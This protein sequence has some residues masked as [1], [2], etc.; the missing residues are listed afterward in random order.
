MKKTN[1]V[2]APQGQSPYYTARPNPHGE[3]PPA[4]VMRRRRSGRAGRFFIRLSA[5]LLGLIVGFGAYTWFLLG[6]PLFTDIPIIRPQG[7]T[8]VPID[9]YT[10]PI[11]NTDGAWGEGGRVR[12]YVHP[13]FPI[14]QVERIDSKVENILVFGV[15][16]RSPA[17]MISRADSLIVLSVDTRENCIKLTSIMRDTEVDLAGR[18]ENEKINAA[19]ALGGVGLL[20]N[21]INQNFGLDIQ[22]F[23]MFDFYSAT[24]LIDIVGGMEI[25][26]QAEE[27]ENLN[28]ILDE[29]HALFHSEDPA[30]HVTSPG[31]QQLNGMQTIA[32]SRI[33]KVGSDHA[34]TG[35]QRQVMM[36]LIGLFKESSLPKK[37]TFLDESLGH[38]ETNLGRSDMMRI[39]LDAMQS[40]SE[41]REYKVPAD[42]RYQTDP[43]NWNMRIDW[44]VQLPALHAFLWG[45]GER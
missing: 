41:M 40:L 11:S 26:V 4:R 13:D 38:F 14:E 31:A 24:E 34:R 33:R 30:P 9:H 2:R 16:A 7:G 1:P 10:I 43:E 39:G 23:A 17:D 21:T 20:I 27:I 19:Y 44:D 32:W 42:G 6:K 45:T 29:M 28:E 15:D 12:V 5:A 25:E 37:I 22:G 36:N 3:V 8:A 18:S 35:R